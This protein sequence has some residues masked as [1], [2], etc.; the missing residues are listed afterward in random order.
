MSKR[1]PSTAS[2]KAEDMLPKTLTEAQA[3]SGYLLLFSA[4]NASCHSTARTIPYAEAYRER[5]SAGIQTPEE[6]LQAASE[7]EARRAAA[8]RRQ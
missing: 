3:K 8:R 1:S 4:A 5:T 7:D 6:R 2:A